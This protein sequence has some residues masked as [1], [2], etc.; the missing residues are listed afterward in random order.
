M[1]IKCSKK[2]ATLMCVASI[3][4]LASAA[5]AMWTVIDV[6]PSNKK[7]NIENGEV[8]SSISGFEITETNDLKIGKFFFYDDVNKTHVDTGVLNYRFAVTPSLVEDEYKTLSGDGYSIK[9]KAILSLGSSTIFEDSSYVTK[10]A[11]K[12]N[13][14]EIEIEG[15]YN[16][17]S[18]EFPIEFVTNAQ[19]SEVEEFDLSFTFS[20]KVILDHKDDIINQNFT[21]VLTRSSV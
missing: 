8:I 17:T 18:L 20:N 14:N 15:N 5:F 3:I 21:L 4:G 12:E 6:Q 2:I 13:E 19:G 1:K 16:S 9:F 7:I 10:I 11:L